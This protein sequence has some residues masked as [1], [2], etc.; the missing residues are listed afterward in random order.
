MLIAMI[1]GKGSGKDT[2]AQVL[3]QECGFVHTR[4]ADPLK[5]MLRRL[6]VDCGLD[7]ERYIEGDL[8]ETPLDLLGGKTPRYAMQTLGTEWRDLIDRELWSSLW[9]AKV[10][11]LLQEGLPVVVTDCRFLHEAKVIRELGG[12]L[13]RI[14]RFQAVSNDTHI[15]E[16]EMRQIE[17]DHTIPNTST[18]EALHNKARDMFREYLR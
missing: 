15:S 2:F 7:P 5:N 8:K 13:I 9:Q 11:L 12:T 3:V 4:F 16:L 14:E 6:F 1:G 10:K 17:A 18:I